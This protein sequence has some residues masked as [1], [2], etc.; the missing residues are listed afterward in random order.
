MAGLTQAMLAKLAGIS[1][2]E[3]NDIERGDVRLRASAARAI[4]AALESAGVEFIG[5]DGGGPGVRLRKGGA[6]GD[7]GAAI[8]IEELTSENDE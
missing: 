7:P 4:Q 6:R 8:P 3:L 2:T 5:E 1:A